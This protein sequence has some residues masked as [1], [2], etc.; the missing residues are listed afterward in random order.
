MQNISVKYLWSESV[1]GYILAGYFWGYFVL[2]LPAGFIAEMAGPWNAIL[3][4]SLLSALLTGLTPVAAS[5]SGGGIIALR[6]LVGAC[7]VLIN[8]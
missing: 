2:I 1:Q 3:W 6:V 8:L 4:S 7:G 5:P